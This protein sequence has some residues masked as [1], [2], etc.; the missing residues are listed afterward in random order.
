MKLFTKKIVCRGCNGTKCDP[1]DNGQCLR[2]YGSGIEK[3]SIFAIAKYNRLVSKYGREEE[4][5]QRIT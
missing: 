5:I 4:K 1:F 3:L 2:C